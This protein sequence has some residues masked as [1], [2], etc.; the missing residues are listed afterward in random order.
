SCGI[1]PQTVVVQSGT[2]QSTTST[3]FVNVIGS[4]VSF[5][6]GGTSAACVIVSFSAQVFTPLGGIIVRALLDG[7]ES[8][9]HTIDFVF[10]SGNFAAHAYNF[11]FPAVSPGGH[12]FRM[13]YLSASAAN[14]T[15][16]SFDLNI[17]HR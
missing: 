16:Q 10:A 11:L 12:T 8:V 17:R 13:Q 9:D 7:T 6:Q 2:P 1:L 14:A 15:I 3:S 4:G 5:T